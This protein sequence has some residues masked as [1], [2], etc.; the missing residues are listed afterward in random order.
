MLTNMNNHAV[1]LLTATI[2]PNGMTFTALQDVEIRKRQYLDAIDYYLTKTPYKIV[3]CEN[4]GVNIFEEI[5]SPDKYQRLE[6]LIL[7]GVMIMIK[8]LEKV[9]EKPE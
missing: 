5:K 4:S 9:M 7:G 8:V 6:Y 1:L 3:F 2:N